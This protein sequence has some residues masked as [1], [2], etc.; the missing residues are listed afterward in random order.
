MPRRIVN[1]V[2]VLAMLMVVSCPADETVAAGL[3]EATLV[4]P[5]DG[6]ANVDVDPTLSVD[7]FDADGDDLDVTFHGRELV[8]G[9]DAADFTVIAI[10]DTQYYCQ[11]GTDQFLAQTE[12]IVDNMF[13]RN[14]VFVT[15]LGDIVDNRDKVLEEWEVADEAMSVLDGMVPYGM[16]P[17]N[18]DMNSDGS[19]V[20]Y[21]QTFPYT[22][23]ENELWYGGHYEFSGYKSN[24]QLISASGFDLLFLH[25][26]L[27][28]PDDVMA[29]A[30]DVLSAYP[31][32]I[33]IVSTH[34][35]MQGLAGRFST[36]YTRPDGNSPEALWD[37]VLS[38]HENVQLVLCGHWCETARRVDDNIF[39]GP[40]HQV[41]IDYQCRPENG[42]G[43]LRTLR[44]S[45]STNELHMETYSPTR[46][47]YLAGSAH[48]FVLPFEMTPT[49]AFEPLGT[50]EG[51]ASGSTVTHDWS[52]LNAGA[53]HEWY[54][55]LDDGGDVVD[56]PTWRF[57]TA[58][59]EGCF[60]GTLF[61]H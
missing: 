24:Y 51:V 47:E 16:A 44:F 1:L 54:V 22:R 4:A 46:D 30:D 38:R 18:H 37:E 26:E 52:G 10:P 61:S 23:Y 25:L 15:H 34:H 41:L 55:S 5:A 45:P 42:D 17:G 49:S 13:D 36:P 56:S 33:A 12:W 60:L 8:Y 27:D 40:V 57:W 2:V 19:A 39:G 29:W 35:Y 59:G 31:D 9:R 7:V 48:N 50:V 20:Y 28:F 58:P 11:N 32:R 14:I 6:E 43:W 3:P 21:D 53:E